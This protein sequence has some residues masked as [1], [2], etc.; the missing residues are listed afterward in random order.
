MIAD[1]NSDQKISKEQLNFIDNVKIVR[2]DNNYGI[3]AFDH[4]IKIANGSYFLILDDDSY[5]EKGAILKALNLLKLRLECGVIAL[6]IYNSKFNFFDTKDFNEGYIHLF[7]GCGALFRKEVID[8]V[9]FYDNDFFIYF[10]EIDLSIRILEAG[11][12]IYYLPEA[13]VFHGS[14]GKTFPEKV[15]NPFT[16]KNRYF[17]LS[18]N[19]AFFLLKHISLKWFFVYL[20]KWFFNR[21]IIALKFNYLNVFFRSLIRFLSM[22]SL[23]LNKRKVVSIEIQKLYKFGNFPLVDRDFFPFFKK[24]K[25][26]PYNLRKND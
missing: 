18:S 13:K 19:Y 11:Y 26:F 7:V 25:I 17:Y 23:M 22:F 21:L 12:K 6:N 4:L 5:P 15:S 16:S 9:G 14:S 3:G 2:L 1:N 24:S 20:I 10:N 8:K